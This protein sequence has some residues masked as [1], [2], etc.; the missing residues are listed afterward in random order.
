MPIGLVA[1]DMQGGV[2][3]FNQTAEDLFRLSS[4]EVVGEPAK[5][6]LPESL[7]SLT[8]TIHADSQVVLREIECSMEDGRRIPLDVSVSVLAGEEGAAPGYIILFK[9]MTE[10]QELKREVERNQRLA[11]LGRLAA[12]IAHE[13]R[14]P[15]SSIKGFATYFKERYREIP[16]DLKTAEIM[17]Q[18]V[19]R[20]NRVISQLLEFARPVTIQKRPTSIQSIIKHS[21]RMI[22]RDAE[23]RAVRV[24]TELSDAV[25]EVSVDPDRLN[26]V[27]LN[28]YLNAL[29]AMEDG[30]TLSVALLQG[31]ASRG[32]KIVVSDTGMGIPK[33]DLEHIFD[34]YFTT[35]QSGT[36]LG[37]AI[38]H[39]VIES[40]K[41]EIRVESEPGRGTQVEITL[42]Y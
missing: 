30:G 42:P 33:E 10:V 41:G 21:L 14:N 17:I 5:E 4:Q 38:V 12:G 6:I 35:K 8:E 13:I 31:E 36:G 2:I 9:D 40:H 16:E 29:E 34:P 20:L 32:I 28:L 24:M 7:W 22:E 27:F 1:V 19:E 39:K 26:Q 3:S 23:E 37:L 25:G 15:L 11:S 18:E